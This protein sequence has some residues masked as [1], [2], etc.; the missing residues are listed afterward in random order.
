MRSTRY[1]SSST[2]TD[3]CSISTERIRRSAF[4]LRTRIPIDARQRSS[5]DANPIT[6]RKERIG[7][8]Q[9]PADCRLRNI[10]SAECGSRLRRD[11]SRN[12][13]LRTTSLHS[14][15]QRRKLN[16]QVKREGV[17]T[18]AGL[19]PHLHRQGDGRRVG[20]GPQR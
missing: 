6:D 3:F 2:A 11:R 20:G 7:F 4:F 16:R 13:E 9:Q 5:L 12:A 19:G 1:L 17:M 18:Q 8:Y 15:F 10:P 14:Q